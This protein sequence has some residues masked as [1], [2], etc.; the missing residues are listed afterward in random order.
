[1]TSSEQ[2]NSYSRNWFE[3]FHADIDAAR[4]SREIDFICRCVPQPDFQ[5]V[6]DV[7]CGMGRHSRELSERGYAVTGVDRDIGAIERARQ[8]AGGASYI[9]GDIRDYQS[10]PE[11]FDAVI[12]MGQSFGQFDEAT[13]LDLLRRLAVGV[14]KHGRIILDLWNPDFFKVHQGERDLE[15][16]RGVVRENKHVEG[17]RLFTDLKYPDGSR[18]EFDWQ[19]FSPPEMERFAKTVELELTRSCSGFDAEKPPSPADPRIQFVLERSWQS[20]NQ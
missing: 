7:C 12:I 19:L 20:L 3:F 11:W 4:T 9:T 8:L 15:T 13:N 2:S 6:L 10:K 16:L 5:K 17:N 1:V 18:E 14:R